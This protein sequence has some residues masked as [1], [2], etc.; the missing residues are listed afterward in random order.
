MNK[1][2]MG[3]IGLIAGFLAV[4]APVVSSAQ[5]TNTDEAMLSSSKFPPDAIA[6]EWCTQKE[7]NRAPGRIRF[8]RAD[9][10]TYTG[11]ISWSAEPKNDVHNK[12]PKLRGR[13][14]V[15]TVLMWHLRYEDGEYVDGYVYNPEDGGT[16][17]V[18]AEV[19]SPESLKIRGY[20][21][22]SLFGQT[23]LWSRFHP[24][25]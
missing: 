1:R 20:L 4:G 22:I 7:E 8:V 11:V 14:L 17:R 10:G 12:D 23:K 15:G 3:L 16:Y 5:V 21:G 18:N 6:G 24:S 2:M 25:S 13:P 9:D 19:L